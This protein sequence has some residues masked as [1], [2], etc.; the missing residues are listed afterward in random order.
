MNPNEEVDLY[1]QSLQPE[2]K[3]RMEAIRHFVK[4]LVP[5]A[6]EKMAYGMPTFVHQGT[7][8]HYA[9]FK[10]HIGLYPAGA[11]WHLFPEETKNYAMSKGGLRIGENQD[12]PFDLI[13]KVVLMRLE[14]NQ[15]KATLKKQLKTK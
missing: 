10:H 1:F 8:L 9:A 11:Y 6:S 13:R 3:Q 4:V 15:A 5:Q 2:P 7:L 14:E 12:I